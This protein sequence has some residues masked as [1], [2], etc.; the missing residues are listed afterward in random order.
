MIEFI[1]FYQIDINKKKLKHLI[2]VASEHQ[3]NFRGDI[4]LLEHTCFSHLLRPHPPFENSYIHLW[5]VHEV[6]VYTGRDNFILIVLSF[7]SLLSACC[8]DKQS[9]SAKLGDLWALRCDRWRPV[10]GFSGLSQDKYV[11]I[12]KHSLICVSYAIMRYRRKIK[13]VGST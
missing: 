9:I 11:T 2:F 1:Y 12:T 4:A 8:P 3:I 5:I 13:C 6:Q 7:K 10:A